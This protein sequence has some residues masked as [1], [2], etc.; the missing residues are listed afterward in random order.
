[1]NKYHELL[2]EQIIEECKNSKFCENVVISHQGDHIV[3]NRE[4][5]LTAARLRI[6]SKK[7]YMY[8]PDVLHESHAT[9]ELQNR[10]RKF[11][12]K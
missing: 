12:N 7:R 4:A 3:I 9:W 8:K 1:M 11:K 2:I 6:K 10:L 5:A